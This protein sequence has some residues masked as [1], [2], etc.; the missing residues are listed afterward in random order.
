MTPAEARAL[1]PI[2]AARAYLFS[3]GL[4]PAATPVRAAHDRWTAL[5]ESDP[6]HLYAHYRH[7]WEL[8]RQAFAAL[9]GAG[10]DDAAQSTGVVDVDVRA[11]G[12]DFLS[13]TAM[14]WLLGPPGVGFF[15]TAREHADRLAPAQAGVAGVARP[16]RFDPAAG[17]T[18]KPGALRYEIGI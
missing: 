9:I 15:F 16:P 8:A 12:V 18:F 10:P 11:M 3:G 17:L 1:F 13:T 2:T 7:E 5:W 14:K 6:G 4:A